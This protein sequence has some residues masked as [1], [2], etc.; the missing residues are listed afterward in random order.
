MRNRR[1]RKGETSGWVI[2]ALVVIGGIVLYS[3][4]HSQEGQK[5]LTKAQPPV[6]VTLTPFLIFDGYYVNIMNTST[7]TTIY[8]VVV[9]YTGASGNT[10]T[11]T[12]K[13]IQPGKTETLDPSDVDWKVVRHESI[14]VSAR[15]YLN[16]TL[17]TNILIDQLK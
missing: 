7:D 14:S 10:K 15:G 17:E 4:Y 8:D 3:F 9:T 6:Q 13:M 16:K 11:Q 5:L 2:A 12:I 1:I